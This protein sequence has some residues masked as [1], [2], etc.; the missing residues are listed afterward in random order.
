MSFDPENPYT[1]AAKNVQGGLPTNLQ[2][3]RFNAALNVW[4]FVLESGGGALGD[5][6]YLQGKEFAGDLLTDEGTRNTVG[7]L[8]AVTAPGGKDLYLAKAKISARS[9]SGVTKIELQADGVAIATWEG[10]VSSTLNTPYEFVISG[11]KVLTTEVLRIEVTEIG[12]AS[13]NISGE[14]VCV[15]VDTGVDPS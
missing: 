1:I 13:T 11:V 10:T 6:A 7:T 3:L 15:Q 12:S 5:I 4:E 9:G 14:I 2:I 8:A